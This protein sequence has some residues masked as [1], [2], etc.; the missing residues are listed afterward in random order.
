MRKNKEP[1]QKE[2]TLAAIFVVV[3]LILVGLAFGI[4]FINTT[5]LKSSPTKQT[6]MKI[7]LENRVIEDFVVY[8]KDY[9]IKWPFGRYDSARII[10][11]VRDYGKAKNLPLIV[12]DTGGFH[13]GVNREAIQKGDYKQVH[14]DKP[15]IKYGLDADRDMGRYAELDAME[16]KALAL[17]ACA[18]LKK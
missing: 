7:P 18:A 14:V 12:V 1:T 9:G 10:C 15:R 3:P 16:K 5:L 6:E 13:Y 8:E 11:E 17:P 4:R 2:K